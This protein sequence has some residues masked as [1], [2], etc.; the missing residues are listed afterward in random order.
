M[1]RQGANGDASVRCDAACP[2]VSSLFRADSG[3]ETAAEGCKR[4]RALG[5]R[6]LEESYAYKNRAT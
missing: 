5:I 6:L 3:E 1:A 2:S 4:I